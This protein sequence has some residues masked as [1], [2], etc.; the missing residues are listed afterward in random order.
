MKIIAV[1]HDSN[2]VI[3]IIISQLGSEIIQHCAKWPSFI[4]GLGPSL[5]DLHLLKAFLWNHWFVL[6]NHGKTWEAF[7]RRHGPLKGAVATTQQTVRLTRRAQAAK[8]TSTRPADLSGVNRRTTKCLQSHAHKDP[9]KYIFW[10]DRNVS[11]NYPCLSRMPFNMG[12]HFTLAACK[13]FQKEARF[14]KEFLKGLCKCSQCS[15]GPR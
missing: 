1:I 6:T 2:T 9:K 11:N 7:G 14:F 13:A 12:N 15:W 10:I 4:P 8:K 5:P 3:Q